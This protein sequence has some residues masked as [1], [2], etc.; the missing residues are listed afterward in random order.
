MNLNDLSVQEFARTELNTFNLKEFNLNESLAL[1]ELSKEIRSEWEELN[2]SEVKKSRWEFFKIPGTKP[3]D[4]SERLL[5]LKDGRK[6]IYGI[7]HFGGDC[8]L[9]FVSLRPNF[10]IKRLEDTL[11]LYRLIKDEL[12]PFRAQSLCFWS[13]QQLVIGQIHST[14]LVAT[15]SEI[16]AM[17][18]WSEEANL[19]LR[20][21][22]DDSY[23]DYYKLG[24]KKFHLERP[25]LKS[26]VTL[27][28]LDIM[29][30]SRE[31]GLLY[32]VF[33]QGSRMGLI[34]AERSSLLGHEGLYFNEIFIET[35]WKGKGLAKALQRKFVHQYAR[36]EDLI[37]GTIDS[38]N[39]PSYQTAIRNGR[40]AIRFESFVDVFC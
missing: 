38:S 5:T 15:A 13:N 1:N 39:V 31:Q 4:Y 25:D 32:E 28:S 30:A 8:N 33:Y 36:D 22:A 19:V 40:R 34:A 17:K 23:Y 9:P 21:S 26:K 29:E 14:Y 12:A 10:K 7:R 16:K 11:E 3:E 18:P 27:N 24:Y 6:L 20:A 37:W 35:R 2:S